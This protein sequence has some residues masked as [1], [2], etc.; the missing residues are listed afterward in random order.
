MPG[1][2]FFHSC[3][4]DTTRTSIKKRLLFIGK[5]VDTVDAVLTTMNNG[6]HTGAHLTFSLLPSTAEKKSPS[7]TSTLATV[8]TS[9]GP[10][11]SF[12]DYQC[13][14]FSSEEGS[15]SL[16]LLCFRVSCFLISDDYRKGRLVF[17]KSVVSLCVI[18]YRCL[19]FSVL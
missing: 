18:T 10:D 11:G 19:N 14:A 3:H 9:K 6:T 15:F 7:I 1:G 16:L 12:P 8:K 17:I 4:H 2:F 5:L 13:F